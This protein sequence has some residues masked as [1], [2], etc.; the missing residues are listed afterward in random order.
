MLAGLI[1][2]AALLIEGIGTF[3][4]V[5]GLASIFSASPLVLLMAIALDIGKVAAVTFVYKFWRDINLLIKSYMVS[6]VIVLMIITSAG[7][8][9]FLS[10]EFQKAISSTSEQTVLIS[11]LTEERTRLQDRKLEIDAQVAQLPPNMVRGRTTLMRQFEPEL[12]Q[13]NARLVEIDR[14]LPK[15]KMDAIKKSVEVGPIIY[16]AEAFDTTPEKAVKWVILIIIFV[17]DP[18][19][20]A[21]LIAG[22]F[23]LSRKT[24]P[25]G[26]TNETTEEKAPTAVDVGGVPRDPSSSGLPRRS[27]DDQK[28]SEVESLQPVA[29]NNVRR[30]SIKTPDAEVEA[31]EEA[32]EPQRDVAPMR[33]TLEQI[34]ATKIDVVFGD[35][36]MKNFKNLNN[37]YSNA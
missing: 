27:L 34:D 4:S 20:I 3:I 9:G 29:A 14:E 8:F 5:L 12:N 6:A 7:V 28:H 37:I 10:A 1:L 19:A 32:P 13:I 16:I 17:F 35:D 18:L 30:D 24:E 15:L 31:I 22:N 11:A 23:L 36:A 33:S 2:F 21:L 25:G 26:A